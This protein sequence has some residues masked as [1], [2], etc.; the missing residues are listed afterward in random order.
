MDLQFRTMSIDGVIS[1]TPD[2]LRP[3]T[4]QLFDAYQDF[5]R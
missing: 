2:K 4:R 5:Y 3:Y 1:D